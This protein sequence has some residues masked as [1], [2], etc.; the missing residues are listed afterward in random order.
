VFVTPIF[1]T[2]AG[3]EIRPRRRE[4]GLPGRGVSGAETLKSMAVEPQ[5]QRR[6]E[7]QLAAYVRASFRTQTWAT[8]PARP[9]SASSTRSPI[10]LTLYF[11]AKAV[12]DGGMT[13][14]ELVAFNMLAGPRRAPVLRIAQLWQD[15]QQTRI[16]VERLGDIL[17]TPTECP[18]QR[19][20]AAGDQGRDQFEHVTF[21]Y[22]L[23]GP[24]VLTDVSLD[25][26]AGQVIGIVGQSGSGKST[27]A[28]LVQR[29]YVPESGRVYVDGVDLAMVDTAW[30]RRQ[31]GVVLQ[32][33][34]LFNRTV[35]E[36]I[37]LA[38]PG[39]PMERVIAAAELAGAHE[40]ILELP[41]GYD[42]MIGERGVACRAGS[43][44][45]SPSPGRWMTNPRILI[46]DEAT[47]ALDYDEGLEQQV[48]AARLRALLDGKTDLA[49]PKGAADSPGLQQLMAV[50]RQE[51]LHKLGDHR[52]TIEALAQERQ[53]REAEKR[54]TDADI[55]RLQQ[56]VPL[57]EE[58]ARVKG[59]LSEDGYVSRTEYLQVQQ[60]YIDRKQ[61]LE[62][63]GH[64]L[65]EANAAIA[66]VSEKLNQADEQFRAEALGQLAEAEQKAASTAQE[67]VKASDRE[68]HYRL[69]APVSGTVQQLAVHSTGA[70]V[71]QAQPLLMIV[72]EN[73]GIA[74]EAA[75]LNKDAGFV[76]PGQAVE[77][78]VEAFPF[79][80]FGTVPGE[81]LTVSGDAVQGPD[82]DPTQRRPSG[83]NSNNSSTG[84]TAE[85]Q[86]G[87]Y[88]V[89]VKLLSD[90]IRAEG[91]DEAL[92]PGMAVTAEIKTGR[93]RVIQYLLDPVLRFR[94]ESLRER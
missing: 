8:S 72:P 69:T 80:R 71:S 87:V 15:F 12:I 63:A 9:S 42:T 79:T 7:E 1:R 75:L 56:T 29:L 4:P 18:A 20:L 50:N 83:N 19:R 84:Q 82:S 21:R 94:D 36:N 78:K 28:K 32:E 65:A 66:N 10:V 2:P 76:L 27:L 60:D 48:T 57:L 22:R 34:V 58:R 3:R 62:S 16:S 45:A 81:V 6:W 61:E 38:D 77:V 14:G 30:L 70:V 17:N 52:A 25:F 11:G 85:N 64:K 46:F 23:D 93:R 40:F 5:M 86:G 92:T 33:S 68:R 13:V 88:S 91:K 89:R 90:H 43:A 73:E 41:Q 39:M 31:I 44:S 49:A 37:A 51:L 47:S 53:Q 59:Q 55:Q 67:L 74:V 35:R 26:P 24:P 54:A